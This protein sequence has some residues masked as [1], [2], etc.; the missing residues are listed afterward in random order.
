MKAKEGTIEINLDALRTKSF[1][2]EFAQNFSEML[3][4]KM[5]SF[6]HEYKEYIESKNFEYLSNL[7]H[8][9]VASLRFLCLED[10]CHL[11][12]SYKSIDLSNKPMVDELI[13][14]VDAN[15]EKLIAALIIF[16]ETG[17]VA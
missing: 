15:S 4:N 1:D 14:D 13:E 5:E 11:I 7:V 9:V 12:E 16:R 10:M 17:K 2:D 8:D 3:I 6:R